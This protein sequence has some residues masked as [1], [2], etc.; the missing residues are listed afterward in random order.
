MI[1]DASV[2]IFIHFLTG[3]DSL[4]HKAE[5]FVQA[6]KVDP[7]ALL[8]AR[9]YPDMYTFTR[10]VQL[11]TDFAKGAGARLAGVPVPSY[12]DEEK[13]FDELHAR[14]R[15]VTDFLRTLRKEQFTDAADRTVTLKVGGR[16]MSFKGSD[17]LN[18]FV[19]P[20]FYFH[21]TTAYDLLRHNGVE[22]GKMDFMARA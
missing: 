3:L 18:Q 1:Y 11:A 8:K 6:K 10:Q 5:A 16:E 15:K 2:P 17:Y 7:D 20:N 13:T 12:P 19:L 14:I 4:L 9:L 22:L 21:L